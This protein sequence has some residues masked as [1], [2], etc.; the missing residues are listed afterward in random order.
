MKDTDLQLLIETWDRQQ[1]LYIEGREDRFETMAYVLGELFGDTLTICDLACGP[2]SGS[3]RMLRALP[4]CRVIGLDA[5]PVLLRLARHHTVRY[6][7]RIE[8]YQADLETDTWTDTLGG[9]Q[10]DA[11]ISSTALHWLRAGP[12]AACYQRIAKYMGPGGVL[13]NADHMRFGPHDPVRHRLSLNR[14]ARLETNAKAAGV[15]DWDE[16]WNEVAKV[17]ELADDL[18]VRNERFAGASDDDTHAIG[19]E[20]HTAALRAA[21]FV[22]VGPIW[23][24]MDDYVVF[25]RLPE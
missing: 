23:Q 8:L 20:F 22:E 2:G 10:I 13:M 9:Q 25:A 21:G 12:L 15:L 19:L 5:D 4:H 24:R 1:E 3:E 14:E 7:H 18:R 11:V 16:W 6:G 17:D